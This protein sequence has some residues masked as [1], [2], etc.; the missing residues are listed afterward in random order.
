M[1]KKQQKRNYTSYKILFLILFH[2]NN[3]NMNF[4]KFVNLKILIN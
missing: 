3:V 2:I 4:I 1:Y